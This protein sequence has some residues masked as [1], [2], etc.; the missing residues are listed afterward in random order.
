MLLLSFVICSFLSFIIA[1]VLLYNDNC[2]GGVGDSIVG[3]LLLRPL[4]TDMSQL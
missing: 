3:Q 2:Y 4:L 1:I